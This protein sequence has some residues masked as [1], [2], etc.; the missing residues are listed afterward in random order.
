[1]QTKMVSRSWCFTLNN[2]TAE[3]ELYIKN[4][5]TKLATLLVFGKEVGKEGT[6]HLQG[7]VC[8]KQTMRLSGVKALCGRSHWEV[9]KSM[10]G[11]I[12]YCEK[13]GD[14]FQFGVK[15]QQGKRSDIDDAVD[16][17]KARGIQGVVEDHPVAFLKFH[18]GFKELNS[19]FTA[20][21]R[22]G[23]PYIEWRYGPTGTG[24]TKEVMLAYPDCFKTSNLKWFNGYHG[25]DVVLIDDFRDTMCPMEQMLVLTD[26]YAHQV[27]TKGGFV[28]WKPTKIFIT[29]C[30]P[31]EECYRGSVNQWNKIDQLTRRITKKVHCVVKYGA[32][33]EPPPS[34]GP[35]D[36]TTFGF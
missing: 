6:P 13:D 20:G 28:W 36:F 27:E 26:E 33:V 32:M 34:P 24:K 14:V 19:W 18:H 16:V 1:M 9:T 10:R 2:Y 7:T 5:W 23:F 12:K 35:I 29:S 17:L 8:F 15:G 11:S 22:T 25:Q 3:E 31:P 4:E 21:P 30:M